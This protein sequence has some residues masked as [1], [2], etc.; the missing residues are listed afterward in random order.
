[1]QSHY[2]IDS[3]FLKSPAAERILA[4]RQNGKQQAPVIMVPCED[5]LGLNSWYDPADFSGAQRE[6]DQ[7]FI[8]AMP[9]D[10]VS[11]AKK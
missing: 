7:A 10:S 2:T 3:A 4:A 5:V 11:D 6:Y 9:E 8:D 1:M